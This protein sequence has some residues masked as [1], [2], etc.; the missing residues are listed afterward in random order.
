MASSVKTLFHYSAGQTVIHR[1]NPVSKLLLLLCFSISAYLIVNPLYNVPFLLSSFLLLYLGKVPKRVLQTF[2]IATFWMC[3]LATL[4]FT[5]FGEARYGPSLSL[6]F[7]TVYTSNVLLGLSISVRLGVM[8]LLSA[9]FFATTNQRDLV[10]GL[11][12]L[13]LP[14]PVVFAVALGFRSLAMF[15]TDFATIREAQLSRALDPTK[16]NAI[17]KARK[18]LAFGI[19]LVVLAIKRMETIAS[20]MECRAFGAGLPRTDYHRI[21]YT[22]TDVLVIASLL[23]VTIAVAVLRYGFGMFGLGV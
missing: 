11:R 14:Y 10:M 2:I 18:N 22:L 1:L 9:L 13:K 3:M 23:S 20:A 8:A 5:I 4:T 19:P 12:A 21:K 15:A 17:E 7:F 16:G 6:L